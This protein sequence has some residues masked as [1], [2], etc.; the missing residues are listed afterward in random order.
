MA[1]SYRVGLPWATRGPQVALSPNLG[2]PAIPWP[3]QAT[4]VASYTFLPAS[5]LFF[6]S[7]DG[8]AAAAAFETGV[9]AGAAASGIAAAAGAAAGAA[10]ALKLAPLLL[11]M[12][13]TARA[14][15]TSSRSGLPPLAGMSR[16][17]S[18]ACFTKVS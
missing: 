15:S 3:W 18:M 17:P 4:Q 5:T 6:D 13:T 7:V 9:G 10:G 14:T 11:A 12:Y 8:A 1:C 2:A 16:I